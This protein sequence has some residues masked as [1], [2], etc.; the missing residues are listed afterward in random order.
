MGTST[1]FLFFP[2][3]TIPKTF[4]SQ[5]SASA[6]D[7]HVFVVIAVIVVVLADNGEKIESA[8]QTAVRA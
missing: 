3:I 5:D 6:T 2:A 4:P 1:V 7:R 8:T